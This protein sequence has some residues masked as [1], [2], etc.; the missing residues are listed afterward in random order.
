M[1]CSSMIKRYWWHSDERYY[2]LVVCWA[3]ATYFHPV[4]QYFP[5]LIVQGQGETGKTTL[6]EVLRQICWNPT[7]RSLALREAPLFRTIQDSRPTYL[8][9]IS[10]LSSKHPS[11]YDIVDVCE[12]ET[13]KGGEVPR[14]EP[15]RQGL[16]V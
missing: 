16:Q 7:G 9:D 5:L 12:A 2:D 8:V 13:E 3:I 15:K 11:Y 14:C 10:T 6:L 4:F 1:K